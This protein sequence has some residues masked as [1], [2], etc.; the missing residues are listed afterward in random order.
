MRPQDGVRGSATCATRHHPDSRV[1]ASASIPHIACAPRRPDRRGGEQRTRLVELRR[2]SRRHRVGERQV[3]AL[4]DVDLDIDAGG[5][6]VVLG[7]SG[8]GKSTLL[9]LIGALDTGCAPSELDS[10]SV[11]ASATCSAAG[12]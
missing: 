3:T 7:P 9:N 1:S 11:G 5:L 6:G 8:S 2:V 10:R 12:R 4:A